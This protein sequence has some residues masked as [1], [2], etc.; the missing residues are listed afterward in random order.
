MHGKNTALE[1]EFEN[2]IN[3]ANDD[4]RRAGQMIASVSHIYSICEKIS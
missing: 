2:E 3:K 4:Q 1:A